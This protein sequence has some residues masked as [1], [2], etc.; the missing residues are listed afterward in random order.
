[1]DINKIDVERIIRFINKYFKNQLRRMHQ[2]I[3]TSIS[4]HLPENLSLS[5]SLLISLYLSFSLCRHLSLCHSP[6]LFLSLSLP[7]SLP[8][9]LSFLLTLYIYFSLSPSHYIFISTSLS[10]S[11]MRTYLS[12]VI[13]SKQCDGW[14]FLSERTSSLSTPLLMNF[15]VNNENLLY[16]SASRFLGFTLLV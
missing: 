10:S 14:T 15:I 1:M 9:S 4:L 7:P 3:K 13:I 11:V 6:H 5:S 8:L 12:S 2:I 16:E